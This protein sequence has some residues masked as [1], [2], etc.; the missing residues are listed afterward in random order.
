MLL[1]AILDNLNLWAFL[2]FIFLTDTA[3]YCEAAIGDM[4]PAILAGFI[5][6]ITAVKSVKIAAPMKII[7]EKDTF[8]PR[9]L[10]PEYIIFIAKGTMI[11]ETSTPTRSPTG[12]PITDVLNTCQRT[13]FLICLFVAPIILSCP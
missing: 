8:T 6:P 11:N 10:L 4:L 9:V 12:I 3:L 5:L 7:G 13:S 1:K 2:F